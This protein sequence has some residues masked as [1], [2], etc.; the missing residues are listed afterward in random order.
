MDLK[1]TKM[2]C[3]TPI[4]EAIFF[5]NTDTLSSLTFENFGPGAH[6]IVTKYS[7]FGELRDED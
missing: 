1:K 5:E 4:L 6:N 2:E 7:S 3:L